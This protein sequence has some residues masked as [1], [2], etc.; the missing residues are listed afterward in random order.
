LEVRAFLADNRR[1]EAAKARPSPWLF[2]PAPDLLLG[3]GALYALLFLLFLAAGPQLR[4]LQ[5]GL[6]FPLLVLLAGTP[7]YGAT[8]V[9]VYEKRR[10]RRAYVLFSLWATLAVIALFVV[11]LWWGAAATFFVTLYLTWSPWHYTGQNYGLA[12]MFLRR[13]GVELEP[14]LKRWI[15]A[16][17]LLS[18]ALVF[19]ILHTTDVG[20]NDLPYGYPELSARFQ[21]LG[22]PAAWTAWLAPLLIAANLVA[23]GRAAFGLRGASR[24]ALLPAALLA[25]SQILWFS[26]PY[27][28]EATGIAV[29]NEALRWDL[30]THYFLW[31]A[32]AHS[33]Q[34]LWVTAYYAR[35]SGEWRGQ[36]PHYAKVLAAGAAAWTIP[37]LL[38]GTHTGGPL[39][40]DAGLGLL[41]AAAVNVHHFILD[42]AIWKLRGPIAQI[43]I[44]SDSVAPETARRSQGRPLRR[45]VWAGC[46]AALAL[47]VGAVAVEQRTRAA[48]ERRDFEAVRAGAA[49]LE[50]LGRESGSLQL[51][52]GNALLAERRIAE[53]R[54]SYRRGQELL[55]NARADLLLAATYEQEGD[56]RRA[57][58]LY[59]AALEKPLSDRERTTVL[60]LAGKAWQQLGDHERGLARLEE[61][62][63]RDPRNAQLAALIELSRRPAQP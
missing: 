47:S 33:T 28:L 51:A 19:L 9:R 32:T 18:Y 20:A 4:E 41:V 10:D 54:E 14:G 56:W 42:G 36:L 3:C 44:R 6:L 24:R 1:V 26:L 62:L 60:A 59:E 25:L 15:Y 48:L 27:G 58:D 57:A 50:V 13:G 53:A 8:L 22:V 46:F 16:S 61:A 49:Q 11:S 43:L 37:V 38:F 55:P 17:F 23:L 30:R 40:F 5:P 63:A 34:Y 21:P 31:I 35:Q 45:L 29:A 7:H 39:A 2:G 12:V 52:F